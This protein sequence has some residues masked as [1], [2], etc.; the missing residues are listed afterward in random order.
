M[1][2]SSLGDVKCHNNMVDVA[3]GKVSHNFTSLASA[4]AIDNR[5]KGQVQLIDL[6]HYM[7]SK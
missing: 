6:I 3:I 4:L 2:R 7:N 5:A 1:T